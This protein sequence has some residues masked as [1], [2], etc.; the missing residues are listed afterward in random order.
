MLGGLQ[1]NASPSLMAF[2]V[3]GSPKQMVVSLRNCRETLRFT[4][5]K[6]DAV[7]THPGADVSVTV[8]VVGIV[9]LATGLG[10]VGS[11]NNEAGVQEKIPVPVALSCIGSDMHMTV[12]VLTVSGGLSN[13]FI[14]RSVVSLQPLSVPEIRRTLKSPALGNKWEGS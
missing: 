9:G 8:N 10:L 4:S 14:T 13:T 12:S 1:A 6:T 3:T 7:L 11:F 2:R 5:T